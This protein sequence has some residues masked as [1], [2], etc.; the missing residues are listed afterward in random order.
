M[1]STTARPPPAISGGAG[2]TILP[3]VGSPPEGSCLTYWYWSIEKR[4][5]GSDGR[6]ERSWV[7]GVHGNRNWKGK[8]M[9]R[10]QRLHPD[11][12][13]QHL[14][15]E[16]RAGL[17]VVITG[18]GKGKDLF[19]RGHGGSGLRPRHED[20]HGPV[21]ERGS[22]YTGEW[23]GL[24]KLECDVEVIPTGMGFA[25]SRGPPFPTRNTERPLSR[26]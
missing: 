15:P 23:D 8:G 20:F 17:V 14:K 4:A 3:P 6:E 16:K 10:L 26:P 2:P 13:I 21:H 25:G 11:L 12:P 1:G 7:P 18:N 22:L 24:G 5:F 9:K 19:G